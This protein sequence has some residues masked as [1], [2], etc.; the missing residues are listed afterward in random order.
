MASKGKLVACATR[1]EDIDSRRY[2]YVL[3]SI[4][5]LTPLFNAV[6]KTCWDTYKVCNE[7]WVNAV[8]YMEIVGIII[9]QML[10]GVLGDWY[11]GLNIA[12]FRRRG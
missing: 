11:V 9:G 1:Q 10:V 5:N 6:W 8:A 2:S 12:R 7:T 4:G 3:F